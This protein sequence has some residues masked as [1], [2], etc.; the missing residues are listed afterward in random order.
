MYHILE[1]RCWQSS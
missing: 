1:S